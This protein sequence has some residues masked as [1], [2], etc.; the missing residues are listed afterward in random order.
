MASEDARSPVVDVYDLYRTA[1]LNVRYL[2]SQ[3]KRL[4]RCNLIMEFL[5][6]I[7]A[8]SAVG[9]LWFFQNVIGAWILKGLVAVT[10]F[11]AVLKPLLNLTAKI[12]KKE[13]ML[14]GY[15]GLDHDLHKLTLLIK[16]RKAYDSELQTLFMTAV[17]R[18]GDLVKLDKDSSVS[19]R[20]RRKAYN[21]VLEELPADELYVPEEK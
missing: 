15:R 8:S 9:G 20:L 19:E 11:L 1:R 3:L 2:E 17:D 13:E 4:R 16:Q 6:A 21:Q 12:Q 5:L 18:K 7:T 14:A 10:F